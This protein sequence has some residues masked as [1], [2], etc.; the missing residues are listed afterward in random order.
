MRRL[1][2]LA[3]VLLG[4][5]AALLLMTGDARRP[6]DV[7]APVTIAEPSPEDDA[8][9][10]EIRRREGGGSEAAATSIEAS[11]DS[12]RRPVRK[13][14][15]QIAGVVR[16]DDGEAAAHAIVG[17]FAPAPALDQDQSA[18]GPQ[19][20][21]DRPGG[22]EMRLVH[23][24]TRADATGRF[25]FE[26]PEPGNWI[27][28]ADL[29]PLLAAATPLFAVEAGRSRPDLVLT[30]PPAAWLDGRLIAP[31][32]ARFDGV[33][34][35]LR[36]E[37][38]P[39]LGRWSPRVGRPEI[40][41]RCTPSAD[42]TFRVGPTEVGQHRLGLVLDPGSR[43]PQYAASGGRF[44]PLIDLRLPQGE[45]HREIDLREGFPGSI[46]VAVTVTFDP[47]SP[48]LPEKSALASGMLRVSAEPVQIQSESGPVFAT[49]GNAGFE[50]GPLPPGRW[51][52]LVQVPSFAPWSWPLSESVYVGPAE[53]VERS[54]ELDI[55]GAVFEMLDAR[56]GE[57]LAD[58]TIEVGRRE[59]NG[60]RTFPRA[61]P[62][63]GRVSLALP[64][65]DYMVTAREEGLITVADDPRAW[66]PLTWGASG[67]TTTVLRVPR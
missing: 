51:R 67:P 49:F 47:N 22:D 62:T 61:V 17:L 52:V 50:L 34:L 19:E 38:V 3:L 63:N 11:S 59:Q 2:A 23:T 8:V 14:T 53:R 57:P 24:W 12:E 4:V 60:M 66:T 65:G 46:V 9:L 44:V 55:V 40:A 13:P 37:V 26:F 58:C 6:D 32:G 16:H 45:T 30:L 29:G 42:G 43:V 21:R 5:V 28:R 18:F 36:T 1:A 10:A 41:V 27:V 54:F 31:V 48:Y 25:R 33:G 35:E 64:P 56:T 15:L 39:K 7:V 20:L